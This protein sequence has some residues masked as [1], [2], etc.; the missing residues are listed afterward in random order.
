M[1]IIRASLRSQRMSEDDNM[2]ARYLSDDK[3]RLALG[4]ELD[5]FAMHLHEVDEFE[6]LIPAD[7]LGLLSSQE[8]LGP[9]YTLDH[10]TQLT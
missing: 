6:V 4:H 10:D 9:H 1:A 8:Q 7:S 3:R 2:L 5:W